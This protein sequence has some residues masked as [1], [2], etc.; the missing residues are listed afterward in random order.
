[1]P[2]RALSRS[3]SSA[4][5]NDNQHGLENRKNTR[6]HQTWRFAREKPL[7]PRAS[8]GLKFKDKVVKVE[9]SIRPPHSDLPLEFVKDVNNEFVV[10]TKFS[11]NQQLPQGRNGTSKEELVKYMSKVPGFLQRGEKLQDNAFNIG[12]LDWGRLEKWTHKHEKT[13]VSE[14][15]SR[16]GAGNGSSSAMANNDAL[17]RCREQPSISNS[18]TAH[19]ADFSTVGKRHCRN[20]LNHPGLQTSSITN[21]DQKQETSKNDTTTIQ[22]DVS[23]FSKCKDKYSSHDDCVLIGKSLSSSSNY[24]HEILKPMGRKVSNSDGEALKFSDNIGGHRIDTPEQYISGN[25]ESI[26]LILPKDFSGSAS[27]GVHNRASLDGKSAAHNWGSFSD[28]FSVDE[29]HPDESLSD[30]THSCP[31]N[32]IVETE[33]E[34]D[35]KLDMLVKAQGLESPVNSS[36]MPSHA[37]EKS[38]TS[39]SFEMS[40]DSLR[41]WRFSFDISRMTKSL[42]FRERSVQPPISSTYVSAKS[43]P[44]KPGFSSYT[45]PQNRNKANLSGRAKASPFKRLLDPLLKSKFANQLN[46]KSN[47][48]RMKPPIPIQ[49]SENEK[50]EATTIKAL[51]HLSD[52]SGLPLFKFVVEINNEIFAS[53][54]KNFSTLDKDDISWLYT[55]YSLSRFRKRSGGWKN[56]RVKPSGFGYNV[57]GKMKVSEPYFPCWCNQEFREKNMVKE[58][59]LYSVDMSKEDAATS[60]FTISRELAATVV[61]L[62]GT[63]GKCSN[64]DWFPD[65][66]HEKLG[67]V[68]VILPGADHSLPR[69]GVPSSLINRWRTGGLCDCGGWDIGCK[70]RILTDKWQHYKDLQA[71]CDLYD[72]GDAKQR[73]PF[74]SLIPLRDGLFSVEFDAKI[75]SLQAFSISVALINSLNPAHS[76]N[77]T[78][79]VESKPEFGRVKASMAIRNEGPEKHA[80][81]PPLSPVGRV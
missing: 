12:V 27:S 48:L 64:Y 28:I 72:Q 71:P 34:L 58:S 26:V 9:N 62:P 22:D 54:V 56:P 53:T 40:A 49:V 50:C 79:Q 35:M 7:S 74:F 6:Q 81:H 78:E 73:R 5:S 14:R 51:L 55:F 39:T 76:A 3:E 47:D 29:I 61:N 8:Q 80:P 60:E 68:A 24:D 44:A 43:G 2:P 11:N 38:A 59:V 36:D 13:L 65:F 31:I 21:I 69:E 4:L 46:E 52:K 63:V 42:S 67:N 23:K 57:V 41:H 17:F 37:T 33:T 18:N 77:T 45:E 15:K 10:R 25:Q 32:H 75:S 66:E 16:H 1:M 19:A 20:K 30:I 70:L